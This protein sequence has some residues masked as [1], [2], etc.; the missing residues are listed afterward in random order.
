MIMDGKTILLIEGKKERIM[1]CSEKRA[2]GKRK[3]RTKND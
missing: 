2:F 3:T 1:Q